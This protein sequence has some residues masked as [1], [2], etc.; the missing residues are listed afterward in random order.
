MKFAAAR[1]LATRLALYM[2]KRMPPVDLYETADKYVITAEVSG[3]TREDI[4]SIVAYSTDAWV[5]LE[6]TSGDQPSRI[7]NAIYSLSPL[8]TTNVEAGLK[9]GYQLATAAYRSGAVNRVILCSDG[10]ANV[11]ETGPEAIVP[12]A[13]AGVP[14]GR[15]VEKS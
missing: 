6:P 5:V 9:I 10:V 8:A 7:I 13:R 14:A 12:A 2:E 11:G 15:R 1:A 4:V 3:L